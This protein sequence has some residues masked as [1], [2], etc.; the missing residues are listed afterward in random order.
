MLNEAE[1]N[2]KDSKNTEKATKTEISFIFKF[3]IIRIYSE[4]VV[5]C[6]L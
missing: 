2:D 6:E 4:N 1:L 5:C 3:R